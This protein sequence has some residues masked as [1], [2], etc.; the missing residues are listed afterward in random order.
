MYIG[1]SIH[2]ESRVKQH[3]YALHHGRHHVPDMQADFDEY[4]DDYTVSYLEVIEK[5]EDRFHEYDWMKKFK[6]NIRGY[7][8]NYKDRF[9][10]KRKRDPKVQYRNELLD[11]VRE[12]DD[13]SSLD[14]LCRIAEK[15]VTK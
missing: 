9:F 12:I 1:S 10:E 8:Y 3:F 2:P 11:L 4:G 14:L 7:G 15:M 6:S 5:Y 13:L